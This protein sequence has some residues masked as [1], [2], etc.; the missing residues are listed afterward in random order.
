MKKKYAKKWQFLPDTMDEIAKITASDLA[1]MTASCRTISSQN[2][3][4]K[5]T[6]FYFTG[7]FFRFEIQKTFFLPDT[8]THMCMH[9]AK[10][11]N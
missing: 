5:K 9:T 7:N 4:L 1:A 2:S 6:V 8:Q 3:L 10:F 11:E